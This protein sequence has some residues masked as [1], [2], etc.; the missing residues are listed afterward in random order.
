MP[1][2]GSGGGTVASPRTG[3]LPMTSSETAFLRAVA[4]NPSDDLPRLVDADWL[5]EHG[6]ED[7]V[8]RSAFNRHAGQ[9]SPV[10]HSLPPLPA[11][12]AGARAA[13]RRPENRR[14]ASCVLR[15]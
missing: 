1:K 14:P 7:A 5:E 10:V 15:R 2:L 12:P 11:R 4:E 13:G 6:D 8:R 3:R 9:A